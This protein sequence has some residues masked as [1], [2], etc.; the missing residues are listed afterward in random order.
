MIEPPDHLSLHCWLPHP[1]PLRGAGRMRRDSSTSPV[2]HPTPLRESRPDAAGQQHL[3]GA[4]SD[5]AARKPAGCGGTAAPRRCRIRLRFAEPAGC[6]GTAAPRRCR[7]RL[8]FAEPAGCGG[9]V[10]LRRCRIRL[11]CAKAG[12]MRRDSSTSPVPHPTPLRESRPDAAGQQH[13]AGAASDSA[14]RSRP[15]AAGQQHFAGAAS[16][17]AARKPAGCGGR[18]A[19]RHTIVAPC[20]VPS[21]PVPAPWSPKQERRPGG[22]PSIDRHQVGPGQLRLSVTGDAGWPPPAECGI[23]SS[24]HAR[25]EG[26]WTSQPGSI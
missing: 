11:R 13:L 6:G 14:S 10:A 12:R 20:G 18:L 3:A 25:T 26:A 23:G 2:P 21:L 22:S 4:A 1:T 8:R 7:I 24:R 9:T 16:D 5:S 15:D 17:S 19:P